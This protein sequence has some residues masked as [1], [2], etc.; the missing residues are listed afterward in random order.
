MSK[1]CEKFPLFTLLLA[2]IPDRSKNMIKCN[3]DI[4]VDD[5]TMEEAMCK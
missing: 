3:I 5:L 1:S 4:V 2:A